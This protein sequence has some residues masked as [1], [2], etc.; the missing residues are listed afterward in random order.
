MHVR[1]QPH[2][3]QVVDR[4]R[5]DQGRNLPNSIL[6]QATSACHAKSTP[7]RDEWNRVTCRVLNSET[8]SLESHAEP[9]D[10]RLCRERL[11]LFLSPSHFPSSLRS[12]PTQ[13]R[14]TLWVTAGVMAF[15]RTRCAGIA[16]VATCAPAQNCGQRGS[17]AWACHC[18]LH[19]RILL[20]RRLL[21]VGRW[22]LLCLPRVGVPIWLRFAR[23]PFWNDTVLL[24]L[25]QLSQLVHQPGLCQNGSVSMRAHTLL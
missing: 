7:P 21:L 18:C 19:V 22:H 3:I 13:I 10:V 4:W 2:L 9:V 8:R 15:C 1:V 17:S 11:H 5:G 24:F 6:R 14:C 25:E 20:Q 12:L 23:G 16:V